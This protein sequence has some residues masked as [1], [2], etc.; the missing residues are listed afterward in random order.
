M[1]LEHF[2]AETLR[3]I[4]AG[5]KRGQESA[6]EHGAQVNP[7]YGSVALAN[8]PR[9]EFDV[10]VTVVEASGQKGGGGLVV[11]PFAL[12][13]QASSDASNTSISRIKF[14]VPMDLPKYPGA[15]E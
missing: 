12:G 8:L 14:A 5:V 1:D 3:Q 7:N 15:T 13:G 9:I 11:G 2:V 4:A 6:K 10:A